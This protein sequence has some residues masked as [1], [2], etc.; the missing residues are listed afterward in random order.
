MTSTELR[1]AAREILGLW[2]RNEIAPHHSADIDVI[3]E[4]FESLRGTVAAPEKG[5]RCGKQ[6]GGE[7]DLATENR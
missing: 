7:N 1:E 6:G 3:N 4:G 2:D 5:T